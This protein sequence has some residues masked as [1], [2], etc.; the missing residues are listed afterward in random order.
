[1]QLQKTQLTVNEEQ[2][3]ERIA[4]KNIDGHNRQPNALPDAS[5]PE[6]ALLRQL[7]EYVRQLPQDIQ[8][9]EQMQVFLNLLGNLQNILDDRLNIVEMRLRAMVPVQIMALSEKP[10]APKISSAVP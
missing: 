8:Q 7:G 3:M 2:I 10:I 9:I 5:P 1:M 6:E 4:Q